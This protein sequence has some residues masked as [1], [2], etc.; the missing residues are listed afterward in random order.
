MTGSRLCRASGHAEWLEDPRFANADSRLDTCRC[1]RCRG[2]KLDPQVSVGEAVDKL[3]AAGVAAGPVVRCDQLLDDPQLQAHGSVVTIDHPVAG[4]HRQL[5]LP[6]QMDSLGVQYNRAPL[7]GEHTH[8][9]LTGLLGIDEAEYRASR[10]RRR[11][12]LERARQPMDLKL[13]AEEAAFRDEVRAFLRRELTPE[14][15][16]A[17]RDLSEQGMWTA[18][19]TKAFRRKLG[20]AGY[21]GM[22][23][24][25]EYGGGGRS[26]V[27]QAIFWDEMEYHRA[28]GLDR[29]ITYIPNAIMA[30]GSEA[31]KAEFLPRIIRGELSWFV[32]YSEPEAGSDLSNVKMRA[33]EDGDHF[34]IT[35]QKAFSSDAHMADYG[36][37]LT[38]SDPGSVEASR[39]VDVHH[40]HEEPRHHH[41]QISDAGRMDPP[42]RA[43]RQV[44]VPRSMLVGEVHQGWKAVMGAIDFERAA[45]SS[46]GLVSYQFDRLLAW[47]MQDR[48]GSR[49]IDDPLVQDELVRLS[50]EAEGAK[51]MSY[52]LACLHAKGLRPQ[53]ETSL[54]LLVKRETSR[55]MDV[56]GLEMLGPFAPL[57]TGSPWAPLARRGGGRIPRPPLFPV[58]RRRLRHH[59]QRRGHARPWPASL[60]RD[61]HGHHDRRRP[62]D[63]ARDGPGVCAKGADAGTRSARLKAT[64][65]GFDAKVWRQMAEMGWAGAAFPEEY[66]GSG[67]GLLELALII[68]ALGQARAA[69]PDVLDGGR[70]GPAAARCRLAGAARR[71]ICRGLRR[72]TPS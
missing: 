32:G 31:Q 67:T 69:E 34:V 24:P 46:P 25:K 33:V 58:C 59:P 9:I 45:L 23:W 62:E 63:A 29:A 56:A 16:E 11:P 27:Y 17:N 19:F 52:W 22:G 43:F 40:R 30:L 57:R 5:G 55:R 14:V 1:A 18:E 60:G 64:E 71:A 3:Q 51:V 6:W 39:A 36:W 42:R 72:A 2:R 49:L 41:H 61:Q 44:R 15:W 68:E 20:A 28:P 12:V 21:I 38:R 53:H 37:V 7:L 13:T 47:C 8:D 48:D 10:S 66:G 35:G 54:A 70:G 50:I 26:R 65:H 4:P